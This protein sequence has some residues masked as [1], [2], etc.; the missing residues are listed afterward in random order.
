MNCEYNTYLNLY[1]NL[2]SRN[3]ILVAGRKYKQNSLVTGGVVE[4]QRGCQEDK[5][6]LNMKQTNREA[7]KNGRKEE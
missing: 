3:Q 2:K 4:Q 6:L 7:V 1:F 5:V